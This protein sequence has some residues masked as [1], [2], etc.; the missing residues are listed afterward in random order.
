V[1]ELGFERKA[2]AELERRLDHLLHGD[3]PVLV[4][5]W[6]AEI[7]PELLYWVPFL[8]W[9]VERFEVDPARLTAISRGGVHSW[10]A[11]VAASYADVFDAFAVDEYRKLNESRW[12]ALGGMKQ[13]RF[14]YWD[15][16]V[17]ERTAGWDGRGPVLHPAYLFRFLRRFWKGGL[18]L[19]H[20]LEHLRLRRL[21]PPPLDPSLQALLPEEYVVVAF[22][23]R[24]SFANTDEHRGLVRDVVATLAERTTV[25][26]LDAQIKAD[27]HVEAEIELSERVL[28]PLAGAPPSA[29][30]GL[31][32]AVAARARAWIGTYG[33]RTHIAPTFGVPCISFAADKGEFLPSYLDVLWRLV[34]VTGAPYTLLETRDLDLLTPLAA[35][36]RWAA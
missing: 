3:G 13:S 24:P 12:A 16:L 30:L 9:V 27:D 5:P 26:L 35:A 7:G 23:F 36:R 20:V 28:M 4:G 11:D 8:R 21:D 6:L 25:V 14:T 15:R 19:S 1:T 32:T 18:S 34:R 22:Y 2:G 33:G 10:Y 31:Q 17:L 29:N